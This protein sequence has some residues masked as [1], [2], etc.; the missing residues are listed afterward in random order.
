MK[1]KLIL[2]VFLSLFFA[3]TNIGANTKTK[4]KSS[5]AQ[6]DTTIIYLN[7]FGLRNTKRKDCNQFINDAI[8]T[9]EKGKPTKLVFTRGTYHFYPEESNKR[10]YFE[11]NTT[12]KN[13]RNCAFLFEEMSNLVI[14]GNG[15][16]LIFHEQMQPFTFDKCQDII[17]KN[18]ISSGFNI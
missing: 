5:A 3:L 13:P 10:N 17:L 1:T 18:V 6:N 14:E 9:I 7:E 16:N 11:S 2:S 8:S 4:T 12:D 15:S